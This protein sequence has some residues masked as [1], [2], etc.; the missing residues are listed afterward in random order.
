MVIEP[1]QIMVIE[2]SQI[3]IKYH[4]EESR[5]VLTMRTPPANDK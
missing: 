5:T 2:P 3:M 1:A 4:S